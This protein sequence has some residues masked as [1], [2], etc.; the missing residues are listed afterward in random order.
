MTGRLNAKVVTIA[1]FLLIGVSAAI[2]VAILLLTGGTEPT[3]ITQSQAVTIGE[4]VSKELAAGEASTV[5]HES[6]HGSKFLL[7]RPLSRPPYPLPKWN[8]QIAP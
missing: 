8:P 6:G 4:P 3:P 2:G 5:V 7:A 1:A